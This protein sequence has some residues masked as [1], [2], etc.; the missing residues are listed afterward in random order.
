[1]PLA[2]RRFLRG[3]RK[4]KGATRVRAVF[5]YVAIKT[6]CTPLFSTGYPRDHTST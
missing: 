3:L 6:A 2:L 1:L 4:V 5:L